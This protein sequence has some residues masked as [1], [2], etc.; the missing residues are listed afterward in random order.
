MPQLSFIN[1]HLCNAFY[2]YFLNRMKQFHA[3][4]A[5]ARSYIE[6]TKWLK[7]EWRY[8][9]AHPVEPFSEEAKTTG[10]LHS[11]AAKVHEALAND[12]LTKYYGFSLMT[13]LKTK[14]GSSF[15]K[16]SDIAGGIPREM[17][18]NDSIIDM[19]IKMIAD[20]VKGC[21]ALSSLMIWPSALK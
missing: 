2:S 18:V 6:D 1:L 14:S 4:K 7:Q 10:L 13:V 3:L 8:V 20:S 21:V 16:F 15:V 17:M 9:Q 5:R 11:E 12:V 19:S